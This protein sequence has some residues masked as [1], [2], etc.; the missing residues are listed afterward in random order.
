MAD[1][2]AEL[3][4]TQAHLVMPF[5]SIELQTVRLTEDIDSGMPALDEYRIDFSL[6]ARTPD[7]R[8]TFHDRWPAH[9]FEA[10]GRAY[11]VPAG[12]EV[13]ARSGPGTQDAVICLLKRTK[14][15]ALTSSTPRSAG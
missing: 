15:P 10:L 5:G 2:P 11:L 7:A 8:M 14:V 12:R 9:R 4:T 6:T 3:M 1:T 13:R